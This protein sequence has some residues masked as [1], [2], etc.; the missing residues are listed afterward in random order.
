MSIDLK[1]LNKF[2]GLHGGIHTYIG[3]DEDGDSLHLGCL[4]LELMSSIKRSIDEKHHVYWTPMGATGVNRH[5][6]N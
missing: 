4:A 2:I 3:L 5:S 1:D 6:S